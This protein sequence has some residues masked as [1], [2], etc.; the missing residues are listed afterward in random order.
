M[1]GLPARLVVT[2]ARGER[3]VHIQK[4]R[5]TI[6]RHSSADVQLAGTGVSGIH[7]EIVAAATG[8]ELRDAKSKNGTFVNGTRTTTATLANGDQIE[9]GGPMGEASLIFLDASAGDE[10]KTDTGPKSTGGGLR[11][12]AG[13]LERL[14]ALGSGRV[15]NDVLALVLDTAIEVTGADRG[16]I[17]LANRDKQLEFKV[18]R[19]R[20]RRPLR[21]RTFK[22]SRKIPTT[23]FTTGVRSIIRDLPEENVDVQADATVHLGIRHIVCTPLRLVRFV[24]RATDSR[25]AD[26]SIGVLYL[27]SSERGELH[28]AS[29][30]AAL[31]TLSEE[32]ALAIEN[33]RLYREAR[34]KETFDAELRVAADIQRALL[35]PPSHSGAYF[36]AAGS[37]VPCR[38]IGGDFFDYVD[39][40]D[41]RLGFILGDVAG[42][43]TPAALLATAAMGMFGADAS[44]QTSAATLMTRLNRAVGRRAI[45]ARFLTAFYGILGGDG[46]L[47]C[48]NAGHNAP[49]V[50]SRT[51]VRRLTTGGS[52][53]GFFKDAPFDEETVTLEHGD[54]VVAFSDGITEALNV[55]GQEFTDDRLIAV[56]E[57]HRGEP[58]QVVVDAVLTALHGFCGEAVQ[59]DDVTIVVVRYRG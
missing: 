3:V 20:G 15:V 50:V 54:L 59:N 49:L 24:E 1:P 45:A 53:V 13:L 6:G 17:M 8:Y 21:G 32:A 46:R 28:S 12:V 10:T 58:P 2:D 11:Q 27:D 25:G 33:A 4:P 36:E 16:F 57:G 14:R 22:I 51:G 38:A 35:P 41:G 23:V 26:S 40:D 18:A 48:C 39:L 56:V 44:Y 37:S 7:A 43:G 30:L 52:V 31:E 5:L 19:E 42:K 47:V 55:D 29:T 9:L 34:A